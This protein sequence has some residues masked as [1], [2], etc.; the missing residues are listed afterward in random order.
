M[1]I[2]YLCAFCILFVITLCPRYNPINAS[3]DKILNEFKFYNIGVE[4]T[5]DAA[6]KKLTDNGFHCAPAKATFLGIEETQK[7]RLD[8]KPKEII[9]DLIAMDRDLKEYSNGIKYK[10]MP[11]D[12]LACNPPA[13]SPFDFSTYSFSISDKSILV[14]DIEIKK[15]DILK[16][17]LTSKFGSCILEGYCQGQDNIV[18][19]IKNKVW[20]LHVYFY[21]NIKP[22]YE[23]I[24]KLKN[25]KD[26]KLKEKINDAF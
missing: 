11:I 12:V 7:I 5:K 14:I 10:D 21:N 2:K 4:D 22:H 18:I 13:D 24:K 23:K 20:Q 16:E 26:K 25:S 3:S 6:L 17:K 19:L 9:D 8:Q 1:K 15:F